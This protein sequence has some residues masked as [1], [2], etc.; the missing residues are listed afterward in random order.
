MDSQAGLKDD[1]TLHFDSE[2]F[3]T[4]QKQLRLRNNQI[5]TVADDGKYTTARILLGKNLH[6]IQKFYAHSNWIELDNTHPADLIS[7]VLGTIAD[8]LTDTCIDGSDIITNALTSGY[9]VSLFHLVFE[10]YLMIL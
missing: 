8:N 7:G 4:A 5:N 6:T 10:F 1:P 9:F 2:T 3:V